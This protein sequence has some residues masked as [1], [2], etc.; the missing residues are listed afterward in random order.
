MLTSCSFTPLHLPSSRS[1]SVPQTTANLCR[2]QVQLDDYKWQSGPWSDSVSVRLDL[3]V[4]AA[5]TTLPLLLLLLGNLPMSTLTHALTHSQTT[6]RSRLLN[7]MQ[8][9]SSTSWQTVVSDK[10]SKRDGEREMPSRD[11][12]QG[13]IQRK[14]AGFH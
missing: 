9:T 14:A 7:V 3:Y 4:C 12:M 6:T 8:V 13:K 5:A 1:P 10:F 11:E 2:V